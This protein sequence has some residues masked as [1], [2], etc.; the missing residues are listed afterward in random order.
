[1]QKLRL[2]STGTIASSQYVLHDDGVRLTDLLRQR[3]KEIA[4][5]VAQA[6]GQGRLHWRQRGDDAASVSVAEQ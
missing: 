5:Y 2:P 6:I 4:R 1:M 3:L